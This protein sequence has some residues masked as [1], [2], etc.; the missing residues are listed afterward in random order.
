MCKLKEFDSQKAYVMPI[1]GQTNNLKNS[2]WA[3]TRS[4]SIYLHQTNKRNYHIQ[5]SD[6]LANIKWPQIEPHSATID[7]YRSLVQQGTTIPFEGTIY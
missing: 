6:D 5:I 1:T 2:T 4:A 7:L 3:I